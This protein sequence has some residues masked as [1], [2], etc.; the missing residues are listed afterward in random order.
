MLINGAPT[1]EFDVRRGL[2]QGDP[3]SPF[4]FLLVLEGF[5]V[6]ISEA[7]RAGMFQGFRL[8]L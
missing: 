8:V 2:R 4:L 3:L 5:H 6:G 7:C 1:D